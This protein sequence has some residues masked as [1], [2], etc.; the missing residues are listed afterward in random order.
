[1]PFIMERQGQ[2]LNKFVRFGLD[3]FSRTDE[4]DDFKLLVRCPT[5][6]QIT[7]Y[8]D[9]I[10]EIFIA[11]NGNPYFA[12]SVCSNVYAKCLSEKDAEVT[13]TEVKQAIQSEVSSLDTN[14]FAHLWQ[15]GIYRAG[16]EREPLILQ[17]CR[18]LVAIARTMRRG[19]PI[20]LQN[21]IANKHSAQLTSAEISA[22]LNDFIKREI[23]VERGGEYTFTLPLFALWLRDVGITRLVS[24][25]LAQDLAERSYRRILVTSEVRRQ[26]LAI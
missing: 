16:P 1:M 4:W 19:E 10:T 17:R 9:A 22:V 2:K 11:T 21:L 6:N 15:D 26:R 18:V 7:W 8:D 3:Y 14:S 25:T 24:D 5:D 12:K 20:I 13:D 23:L